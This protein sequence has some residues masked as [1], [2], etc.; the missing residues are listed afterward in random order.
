MAN[1]LKFSLHSTAGL[2]LA[3]FFKDDIKKTYI[4]TYIQ[5][6][7]QTDRQT[8]GNTDAHTHTHTDIQT[9][10]SAQYHTFLHGFLT[11]LCQTEKTNINRDKCGF[12]I[13]LQI[14]FT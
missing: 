3:S 10:T 12:D 7:R 9:K 2:S 8:D 6:D 11:L 4:H 13:L 5:T 14:N 1:N